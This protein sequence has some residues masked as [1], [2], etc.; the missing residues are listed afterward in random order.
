MATTTT[1][2]AEIV[3]T[4]EELQDVTT[5]DL[6]RRLA[7]QIQITARHVA[8]M[9]AIWAELERRG[10]DMSA[11][12]SG[13]ARYLPAVAAGRL[14]PEA[15]VRLAGNTVALR[16]VSSLT[17]D[18]Q[19]RL[20]STGVLRVVRSPDTQPDDVPIT[21]LTT[22]DVSRAIDSVRG[23]IIEPGSQRPLK[24]RAR[25]AATM[26]R[27]A[28]VPLTDAEWVKLQG[29]AARSKRSLSDLIRQILRDADEL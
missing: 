24:S 25:A 11:L 2:L 26:T 17:P 9:A 20:L 22:R 29:S 19:M 13:I 15:V 23:E 18:N 7:E 27:R 21:L 14:V 1:A 10:E 8:H 4:R 12:R 16:A 28:V 3:R 6:R 5:D